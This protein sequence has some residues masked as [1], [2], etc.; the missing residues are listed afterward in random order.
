MP[1]SASGSAPPHVR[2]RNRS[3]S[4]IHIQ[5]ALSGSAWTGLPPHSHP[6]PSRSCSRLRTS[7]SGHPPAAVTNPRFSPRSPVPRA[8]PHPANGRPF[9]ELRGLCCKAVACVEHYT[10]LCS[11]IIGRSAGMCE[12]RRQ[13]PFSAFY[14]SSHCNT[15]RKFRGSSSQCVS[16]ATIAILVRT[17][18]GSHDTFCCR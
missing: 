15:K 14:I 18:D 12:Q 3:A 1:C 17:R 10:P 7:A 8:G 11:G 16:S 5:A 2:S 4:G 13:S 9:P 6:T